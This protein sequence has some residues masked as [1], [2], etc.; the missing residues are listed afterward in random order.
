MSPSGCSNPEKPL[1]RPFMALDMDNSIYALIGH[2]NLAT[3]QIY[4][5]VDQDH[6]AAAVAKYVCSAR[7]G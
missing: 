6:R 4:T 1:I 3:T 5:H 2:V 7:F